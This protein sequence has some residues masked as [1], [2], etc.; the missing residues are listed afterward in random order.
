MESKNNQHE[1]NN[2]NYIVPFHER[3]N[4]KVDLEGA[5]Q[6]FVNRVQNGIDQN[7]L[8]LE[9]YYIGENDEYRDINWSTVLTL[10][11]DKLGIRYSYNDNFSDYYEGASD[12]YLFLKSLEALYE[13]LELL[14]HQEVLEG[15]IESAFQASDIELGIQW[16]NGVFWPSGARLLDVALVNENLGWLSAPQYCNVLMPFE[17]GLRHFLEANNKPERLTDTITDMYE[18]LEAMAKVI[19]GRNN[20]DLSGNKELFVNKVRLSDHYKKMLGDYITYANE[21]RHG[22]EANRER[23]LPLYNEVEAFIYTT[24]LFLR[25]AIKQLE[26]S[27]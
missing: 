12:F 27:E 7:F 5:K 25:L 2:K 24:G 22:L 1:G 19:T 6:A 4:L 16:R 3:F 9:H 17:K 18:A 21:Y 26:V 23:T 13:A 11:A 15:I 8:W 10:V 20:K 14:S